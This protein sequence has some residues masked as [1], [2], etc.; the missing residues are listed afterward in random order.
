MKW[1]VAIACIPE[2]FL[3]NATE[4]LSDP[5]RRPQPTWICGVVEAADESD[6]SHVGIDAWAA[7]QF[8]QAPAGYMLMNW[9]VARLCGELS[10]AAH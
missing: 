6:A 4:F 3:S 5:T 1:L 9:Y 7:G 10:V 8:G 2:D